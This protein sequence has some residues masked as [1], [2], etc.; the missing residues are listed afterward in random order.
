[1]YVPLGVLGAS[2]SKFEQL[3]AQPPFTQTPLHTLPQP[4]QL[5]TSLV[6][7]AHAPLHIVL[8]SQTHEPVTHDW[9]VAHLTPALAP[10]QL[11]LAPQWFGSFCPST[12]APA[13]SMRGAPQVVLQAPPLHTVPEGHACP[14]VPQLALSVTAFVQ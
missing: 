1:M 11:V 13:Q 2:A 8:L 3:V 9:P 12:H 5:F 7:S 10:W 4:P 6:V 14:H